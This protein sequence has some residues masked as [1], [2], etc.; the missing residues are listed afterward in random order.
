MYTYL[1]NKKTRDGSLSAILGAQWDTHRDA[2]LAA[3]IR[4]ELSSEQFGKLIENGKL[5]TPKYEIE[6][7]KT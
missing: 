2:C 6:I 1:A 4:F 7:D 5:D 3:K